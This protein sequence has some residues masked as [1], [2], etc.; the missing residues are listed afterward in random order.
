MTIDYVIEFCRQLLRATSNGDDPASGVRSCSCNA[1]KTH[2]SRFILS[3]EN[4]TNL[5]VG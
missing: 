5:S 4:H 1:T 3:D 2:L